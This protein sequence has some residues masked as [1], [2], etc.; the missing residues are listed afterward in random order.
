MERKWQRI[1]DRYKVPYFHMVDVAHGSGV[2]S[3]MPTAKRDNMARLMI[4]LVQKYVTWGFGVACPP[5]RHD[6][7]LNGTDPYSSCMSTLLTAIDAALVTEIPGISYDLYMED[8]HS[9]KGRAAQDIKRSIG[10]GAH[11]RMSSFAFVKKR[12]SILLQAADLLVW[13]FAKNV[14]D[15]VFSGRRIRKDFIALTGQ[16][17]TMF[18][19]TLVSDRGFTVMDN[20]PQAVIESRDEQIRQMFLRKPFT[21]A[22]LRQWH[23]MVFSTDKPRGYIW[24]GSTSLRLTK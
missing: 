13:Q 2:F 17:H 5:H 22:A 8:G 14:K 7:P 1:L 4:G 16:K 21:E 9:S 6:D 11:D 19:Y 15:K 23:D 20:D 10:L 12:D 3:D 18:Y 24:Q